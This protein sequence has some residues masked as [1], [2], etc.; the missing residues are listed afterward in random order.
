MQRLM[1]FGWGRGGRREWMVIGH[2]RQNGEVLRKLSVGLATYPRRQSDGGAGRGVY[3]ALVSQPRQ[4][5]II[6]I[7]SPLTVGTVVHS[8]SGKKK[9]INH[10][11]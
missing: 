9:K 7:S 8:V 5:L 2:L 4:G 11:K 3:M 1:I 10:N 6:F